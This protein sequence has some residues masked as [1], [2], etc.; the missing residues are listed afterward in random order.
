MELGCAGRGG[1]V[2]LVMNNYELWVFLSEEHRNHPGGRVQ[3]QV[4]LVGRFE[5]RDGK[6]FRIERNT[7]RR[8]T[9]AELSEIEYA[10][11]RDWMSIEFVPYSGIIGGQ[12]GLGTIAEAEY[13][14]RWLY[15]AKGLE[16]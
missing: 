7:F 8:A 9:T 16:V 4:P 12:C 14:R 11:Q 10:A 3:A 1:R 15:Q 2:S 6:I 5:W 13:Q